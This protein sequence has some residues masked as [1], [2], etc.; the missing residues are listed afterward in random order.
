LLH[1]AKLDKNAELEKFC[2]SLEKAV[3]D[4]VEGGIMTKDLAITIYN[5]NKY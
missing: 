1:R 4:T 5:T 2:N 3:V